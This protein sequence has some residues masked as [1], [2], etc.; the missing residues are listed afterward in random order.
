MMREKILHK[1]NIVAATAMLQYFAC[2]L[3]VTSLWAQEKNSP[4]KNDI[5]ID[6]TVT[7]VNE[8][9]NTLEHELQS[10][11]TKPAAVTESTQDKSEEN[12]EA[13][14][15]DS[16]L[17]KSLDDVST[18]FDSFSENDS[19]DQAATPMAAKTKSDGGHAENSNVSE[20]PDET[21]EI[22]LEEQQ[23][24]ELSKVIGQQ[25]SDEEWKAIAQNSTQTSYKVQ[26]G[27]WLF[28]ISK[29]LFGSGFY[30]PKI[31]SLNPYITNPHIIEPGMILVF[32]AGSALMPP[33]MSIQ[34]EQMGSLAMVG[35]PKW[36]TEK[37]KLI[38]QGVYI[39]SSEELAKV[40]G[41][42]NVN[43]EYKKY[44]PKEVD[45]VV[46]PS[47]EQYDESGIDRSSQ[48]VNKFKQGFYLNTFIST[49]EI[50]S[51]GSI[52][53]KIDESFWFKAGDIVFIIPSD[54][55]ELKAGDLY[56]Y[57]LEGEKIESS[58]SEREGFKYTIGGT[59]Q[60][61][62]KRE[63]KWEAKVTEVLVPAERGAKIT[64]YTP[65]IESIVPT[66]N[67]KIIEGVILAG[68]QDGNT[69]FTVGDVIYLDRGRADGL[70]IGN[71]LDV[72]DFV[73]R[74]TGKRILYRPTYKVAELNVISLTDNFAT[75][76]VT[77]ATRSFKQGDMFVA[78]NGEDQIL[79][80]AQQQKINDEASATQKE[81]ALQ[82]YQMKGV[83]D[84][85]V[86]NVKNMKLGPE[87]L[88]E[89][90]RQR[91]Q[92]DLL[93]DTDKDLKQLEDIEK[94]LAEVDKVT[95]KE[96]TTATDADNT[97]AAKDL[98]DVEGAKD[99]KELSVDLDQVEQKYGKKYL[100]EQ[101][102]KEE[103]PFGITPYDVEEVDELMSA[104]NSNEV[105]DQTATTQSAPIRKK[106]LAP[107]KTDVSD[108]L[109][110]SKKNNV[111]D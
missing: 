34:S 45:E 46:K 94:D 59:V 23:L 5:V 38:D 91:A 29:K 51:Y 96:N 108:D 80:K 100:D 41:P 82:N 13:K 27:D 40:M 111:H 60:L 26:P 87:E 92:K 62:Q 97:L 28:K 20:S 52:E 71:V 67:S 16:N 72:Y 102:D 9:W 101:L 10:Q 17:D 75:A 58:F 69:T 55:A 84:E 47:T 7:G 103:N 77:N 19:T 74:G 50:K 56:S 2:S 61:L 31:W 99:K 104:E 65:K 25:M 106:N 73:D 88:S 86:E 35:T 53:S 33:Q 12:S 90:E 89:L 48:V 98:D 93:D 54:G 36:F 110:S 37:K 15:V 49:N 109:S 85:V 3:F 30:Y 14:S 79:G 57:Y 11:D 42:Q 63:D 78:R 6:D 1:M 8:D 44:I 4:A 81:F 43:E 107:S 32:D 95:P 24:I 22:G 64:S 83:G 39:N 70:E 18:D 68:Y 66:F 105:R 76:R 21:F